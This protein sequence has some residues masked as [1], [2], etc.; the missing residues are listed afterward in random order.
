[1]ITSE[2]C[3]SLRTLCFIPAKFSDIKVPVLN[4][5]NRSHGI[6]LGVL[7]EAEVTDKAIKD[8]QE[9]KQEDE[10]SPPEAVAIEKKMKQLPDEVLR[11]N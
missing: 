7:N 3:T 9:T 11:S 1:M 10:L 8:A 4:A 5:E 6:E 2:G